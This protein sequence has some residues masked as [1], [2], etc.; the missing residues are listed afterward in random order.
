MGL[1]KEEKAKGSKKV[2]ASGNYEY[3]TAV[4]PEQTFESV[5]SGISK[6]FKDLTDAD[7]EKIIAAGNTNF[8][9]T[10]KAPKS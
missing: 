2:G 4:H 5:K 7:I 1:T 6:K 3:V 9:K 10:A 8:T